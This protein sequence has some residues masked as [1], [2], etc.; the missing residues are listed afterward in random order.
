MRRPS[1][2]QRLVV[3]RN[4]V[5]FSKIQFSLPPG[6]HLTS[7]GSS[8]HYC[9]LLS[10]PLHLS[11]SVF[12]LFFALS[13][14]QPL[15]MYVFLAFTNTF[16]TAS[17]RLSLT[18]A[19]TLCLLCSSLAWQDTYTAMSD[20]LGAPKYVPPVLAGSTHVVSAALAAQGALGV[21]PTT[22]PKIIYASRTHTQLSQVRAPVQHSRLFSCCRVTLSWLAVI[23]CALVS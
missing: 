4:A 1:A 23:A 14:H 19:Q 13:L 22:A 3:R 2:L 12:V 15:T 21:R 7:C 6:L 16:A 8:I 5:W 11:L 10:C 9:Q 20:E 18:I 17:A